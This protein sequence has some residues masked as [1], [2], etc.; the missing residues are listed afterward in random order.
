VDVIIRR[1]V[2]IN[3]IS[4]IIPTGTLISQ[5]CADLIAFAAVTFKSRM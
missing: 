4:D 2:T 3:S 5:K 1:E